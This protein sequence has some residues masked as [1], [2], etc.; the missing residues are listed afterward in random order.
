MTTHTDILRQALDALYLGMR[1]TDEY[2]SQMRLYTASDHAQADSAKIGAAI[3]ALRAELDATAAQ[4]EPPLSK[5]DADYWLT[6]RAAI[7]DAIERAGFRIMSNAGG[8]WLQP[9]Q[10]QPAP[11]PVPA[12][13][14]LFVAMDDD[15][16]AHLTWCADEAEVHEAVKGAMF[17]SHDG[18]ELDAEH[19]EQLTA[20]VAELL[21]SGALTFEGDAPLFLYRVS[22]A[23]PAAPVVQQPGWQ[24]VPVEPTE[25]MLG[26]GVH[27]LGD[28]TADFLVDGRRATWRTMLAAAPQAPTGRTVQRLT[29]GQIDAAADAEWPGLSRRSGGLMFAQGAKWAQ[30]DRAAAWGLTLAAP[31]GETP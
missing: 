27:L 18:E 7:I 9:A 28:E 31:E 13:P 11:V 26:V 5:L 16:K 23:A 1:W 20:N 3:T 22:A 6:N 14:F 21:D 19:T 2:A 17:F 30:A 8:F 25:E 4:A 10:A 29:K 12:E 24:W 15:K